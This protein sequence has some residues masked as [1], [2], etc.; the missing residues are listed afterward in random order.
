MNSSMMVTFSYSWWSSSSLSSSCTSSSSGS[1]GGEELADET[2][3]ENA[4]I[5]VTSGCVPFIGSRC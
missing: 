2:C 3:E 4:D 5:A 1:A